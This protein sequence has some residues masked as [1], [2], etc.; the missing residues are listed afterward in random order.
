MHING[1]RFALMIF[2]SALPINL[3]A[4]ANNVFDFVECDI[5][6]SD[7][8]H[9]A[10]KRIVENITEYMDRDK[11]VILACYFKIVSKNF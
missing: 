6:E 5:S 1:R 10:E 4:I 8:R 3:I 7:Y 11:P 2:V 9:I